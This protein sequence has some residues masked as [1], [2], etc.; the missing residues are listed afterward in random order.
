MFQTSLG[1]DIEHVV[2]EISLGVLRH[3]NNWKMQIATL[4]VESALAGVD[5]ATCTNKVCDKFFEGLPILATK[6][7]HQHDYDKIVEQLSDPVSGMIYGK[8]V[9]ITGKV[10][11][12]LPKAMYRGY[13]KHQEHK[14]DKQAVESMKQR[15]EAVN[16]AE[17][18]VTAQDM[19]C[20][21]NAVSTTLGIDNEHLAHSAGLAMPTQGATKDDIKQMYTQNGINAKESSLGE[22][23]T[24][25]QA[26]NSDRA[27]V[28]L[29]KG[30]D[31]AG[32][33]VP[34]TLENGQLMVLSGGKK[35]TLTDYQN[36]HGYK[37]AATVVIP[38]GVN[39]ESLSVIGHQINRN[40][41]AKV[42]HPI[43][44]AG[45]GEGGKFGAIE[46]AEKLSHAI[47][48]AQ[49]THSAGLAMPTQG[50]TK[51]DIKQMY[52]TIILQ[53]SLT[54]TLPADPLL[55][56]QPILW[57]LAIQIVIIVR[58]ISVMNITTIITSTTIMI[59]L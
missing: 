10:A 22:A 39:T 31:N 57:T 48:K 51:D 9:S 8:I 46:Y 47:N 41:V 24:T 14:A 40:R 52:T 28:C 19:A 34:V 26:S 35:T 27:V 1:E 13:K 7:T 32:H 36:E 58:F 23:V 5:T 17:K 30:G 4:A 25:L 2:K 54:L 37:G 38:E 50:A 3:C 53:L 21:H 16:A 29:T 42:T 12:T 43:D 45:K 49:M 18:G 55:L 11:L 59:L 15:I 44:F 56:M 20:A 6:T 33:A